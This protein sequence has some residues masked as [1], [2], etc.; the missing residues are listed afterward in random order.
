MN[1]EQ[2]E[3]FEVLQSIYPDAFQGTALI[4]DISLTG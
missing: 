3:E 2:L 4:K 1:Q